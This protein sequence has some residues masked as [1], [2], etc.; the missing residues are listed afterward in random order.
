MSG[1]ATNDTIV[2]VATPPGQG[3]VG[4]VRLSGPA[5]WTIAAAVAPGP[6]LVA[7]QASYRRFRDAQ[8]DVIDDGLLIPFKAPQSF[9]GEDVCELQAH[10]SP[11][12]M[13]QLCQLCCEHGARMARPGEFSERAFLHD[14]LDLVQAEAVADLIAA[15]SD[16]AA[17]AARR[18]LDGAFSRRCRRLTEQLTDLR[19]RIEAAIDFPE[20]DIDFLSDPDLIAR[21]DA[22]HVEHAEVLAGARRGQRLVDGL[23]IVLMGAPNAGKSSLLNALAE[24]DRA[25]VTATPG[26]TRDILRE[27]ILIRGVPV[28][29]IDTAGLRDTDDAIEREGVKRAHRAIDEAD[30][31]LALEAP[32]APPVPLP[33]AGPRSLRVH[34]KIDLTGQPPGLG[35]D[36]SLAVSALTGAGLEVLKDALTGHAEPADGDFSARQRH[37]QAL[38]RVADALDQANVQLHQG[39]GDLAAEDLR[40]AQQRLGEITG[41]VTSDDL[42]GRIFSSFCI[43]K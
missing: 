39:A 20:E 10:G 7:R 4:I 11:I 31:L 42:L 28:T 40:Q 15:G 43:G 37:I 9:T 8:S 22:L 30:I 16:A 35:P 24:N 27:Q 1:V 41:V 26:T 25:I 23:C 12:V 6:A 13:A 14:K 34:N 32:D 29:V 33:A 5:A 17:R 36:Q 21:L 2:A 3:G 38:L 18:S 19:M